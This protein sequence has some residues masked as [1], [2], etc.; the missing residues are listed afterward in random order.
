MHNHALHTSTYF[1]TGA[2]E[3]D[4][5]RVGSHS[6][7]LELG[8]RVSAGQRSKKT[9]KRVRLLFLGANKK[10]INYI[11]RVDLEYEHCAYTQYDGLEQLC[12]RYRGKGFVVLR[13]PANNFGG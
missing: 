7:F 5:R 13:F 2:G 4:S 1:A 8:E 3:I 12:R 9:V 11:E 10:A 6:E